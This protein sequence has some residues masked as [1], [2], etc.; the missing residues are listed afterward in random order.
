MESMQL[1]KGADEL[2]RAGLAVKNRKYVKRSM[3]DAFLHFK[4]ASENSYA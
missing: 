3:R 4:E 2:Y 1:N